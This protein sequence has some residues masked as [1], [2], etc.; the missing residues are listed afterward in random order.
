MRRIPLQHA[1]ARVPPVTQAHERRATDALHGRLHRRAEREEFPLAE[2]PLPP[3][4]RPPPPDRITFFEV[5][6][7]DEIGQGIGGLEVGFSAGP[8]FEAA[9]TNPAGVATLEDV[10]RMSAS[11]RVVS[12]E[13][14][15]EILDPRWAA[16]RTGTT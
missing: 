3:I 2:A 15:E 16:P 4:A 9:T 8:R 7:V 13:Q 10:T 6:F 14:L 5:R 12:V 1:L 11:V